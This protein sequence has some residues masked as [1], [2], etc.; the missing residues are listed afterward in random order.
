MKGVKNKRHMREIQRSDP[1]DP[2]R[3]A[4]GTKAMRTA[5]KFSDEMT[6]GEMGKDDKQNKTMSHKKASAS[7]KLKDPNPDSKKNDVKTS[8]KKMRYSKE[9]IHKASKHMS[10]H[11]R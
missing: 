7:P 3:P 1:I 4:H 8:L 6:R 10:E 11:K 5:K 9:D 2:K